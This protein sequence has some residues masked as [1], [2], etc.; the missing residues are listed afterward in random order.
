MLLHPYSQAKR[1]PVLLYLSV[2]LKSILILMFGGF[3]TRVLTK[4]FQ[5][6]EQAI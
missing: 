2:A 5:P 4:S 1:S 3:F 6:L